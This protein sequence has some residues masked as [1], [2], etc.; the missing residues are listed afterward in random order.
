LFVKE[1]KPHVLH[2]VLAV[3]DVPE[4]RPHRIDEVLSHIGIAIEV[5]IISVECVVVGPS[6]R[7]PLIIRL[8]R[9]RRRVPAIPVKEDCVGAKALFP[10]L[11]QEF[12]GAIVVTHITAL[13]IAAAQLPGDV[14]AAWQQHT[15]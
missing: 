14:R 10:R 7:V 1:A 4:K 9:Y 12:P 11:T 2:G 5:I 13:V 6:H 3:M 8:V 15:A